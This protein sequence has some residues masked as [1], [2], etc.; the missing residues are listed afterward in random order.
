[1]TKEVKRLV[2]KPKKFVTT[3][4][5]LGEKFI[6]SMWLAKVSSKK[7]PTLSPISNFMARF[8]HHLFIKKDVN[9]PLKIY[10]FLHKELIHTER[11]YEEINAL[12]E[13]PQPAYCH[14]TIN[15]GYVTYV[16]ATGTVREM[17]PG[18]KITYTKKIKDRM[19]G[20]VT[21]DQPILSFSFFGSLLQFNITNCL[22][23]P[24]TKF[25]CLELNKYEYCKFWLC[26][27]GQIMRN[28]NG[29]SM[30]QIISKGW[31]E[32]GKNGE[33]TTQEL[34]F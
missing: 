16:R 19:K 1:M 26:R 18:E 33:T 21:D 27:V 32:S 14:A 9:K 23:D 22:A 15:A 29:K 7:D 31:Y 17:M 30:I 3:S 5:H 13:L 12:G 10:F 34:Y 25:Y 20:I 6:R 8:R 4:R 24:K 2:T 28:N 11:M